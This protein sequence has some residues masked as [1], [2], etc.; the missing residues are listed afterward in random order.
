VQV[1]IS[2]T[3]TQCKK[4]LVECTSLF[5]Y[6]KVLCNIDVQPSVIYFGAFS[7]ADRSLRHAYVRYGTEG[8]AK[9]TG[10]RAERPRATL[11]PHF[12][13]FDN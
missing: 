3:Y 5:T 7:I 4:N 9:T 8:P 12:T 2:V 10:T 6:F 13:L 1:T 11:D